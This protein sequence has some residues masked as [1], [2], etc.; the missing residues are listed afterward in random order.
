MIVLINLLCHSF[1]MIQ[2]MMS[3]RLVLNGTM[4]L[5]KENKDKT[6]HRDQ[7]VLVL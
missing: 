3:R 1:S 2:Q 4:P 6:F 5:A 7:L